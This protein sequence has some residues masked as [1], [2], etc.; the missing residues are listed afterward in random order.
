MNPFFISRKWQS[1]LSR[2]TK[3]TGLGGEE[4]VYQKVKLESSWNCHFCCLYQSYVHLIGEKRFSFHIAYQLES[5]GFLL[6][7]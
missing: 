4:K 1:V 3:V 7:I 6:N 2:E 5:H